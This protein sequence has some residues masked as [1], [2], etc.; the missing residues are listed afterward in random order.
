MTYKIIRSSRKTIC[1]CVSSENEV[2]V[3]CPFK[4]PEKKINE[5]VESKR[6]WLVKVLA[7]NEKKLYEN[8]TVSEYGEIYVQGVKLPLVISDINSITPNA[9]YVKNIKEIKNLLITAYSKD[10]INYAKMVSAQC[11]FP[12]NEI[13]V[14]SYKSRWGCCDRKGNITFNYMLF[15]LD[16]RLQRYV[17]IHEL[18]HMVYFDHSKDFWRLVEQ[19]EPDYKNLR[20]Q[21]KSF[22]FLTNLY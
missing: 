17:I 14:K 20:K 1:I 2:V 7:T 11:N 6:E 10:F 22:V 8:Q 19:F 12:V 9:V 3:R 18:C 5:F 15:M 4:M 13:C 16:R 21:L